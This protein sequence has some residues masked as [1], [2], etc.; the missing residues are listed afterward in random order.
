MLL[1]AG[2]VEVRVGPR[3]PVAVLTEAGLDTTRHDAAG[4]EPDGHVHLAG[5]RGDS[6]RIGPD[7]QGAQRGHIRT[8]VRREALPGLEGSEGGHTRGVEG[9]V[10]A[11]QPVA[12]LDEPG[13]EASCRRATRAERH[14]H[15]HAARRCRNWRG[16][17]EHRCRC[18]GGEC[19]WGGR[20]R[21]HRGG[22][23]LGGR[24]GGCRVRF[25]GGGFDGGGRCRRR[26]ARRRGCRRRG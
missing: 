8:P 19:W 2:R 20:R 11:G 22:R 24:R 17:G 15:V 25:D 10:R 21:C 1:T 3:E 6:R 26:R 7:L 14:R 5:R 13:L 12:V 18:P 16:G 9:V 4:T 23:L